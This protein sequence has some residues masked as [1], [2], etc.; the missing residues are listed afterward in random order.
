MDFDELRTG[1]IYVVCGR[2]EMLYSGEGGEQSARFVAHGGGNYWAAASDVVRAA[3]WG[4]VDRREEQARSRGVA[5]VDL[6]CW[7]RRRT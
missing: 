5:C 2:G 6:D 3:D 4:D 1:R 7:C